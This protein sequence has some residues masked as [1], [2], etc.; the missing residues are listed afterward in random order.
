MDESCESEGSS[1]SSPQAT[2][3]GGKK[4][5]FG[6]VTDCAVYCEDVCDL[7]KWGTEK[8]RDAGYE[9]CVKVPS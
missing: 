7:R 6:R 2:S 9:D 4:G 8:Y 3:V 5:Q 1:S